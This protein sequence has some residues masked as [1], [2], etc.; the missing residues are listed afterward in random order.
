MAADLNYVGCVLSALGRPAEALPIHQRALRIDEAAYGL[1]HPSTR[2]SRQ[3]VE[4]L[5]PSHE[6]QLPMESA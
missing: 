1:E 6:N 2:Q 4:Q 3:Y 5:K